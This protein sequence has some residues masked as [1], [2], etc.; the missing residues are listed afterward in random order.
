MNVL[1]MFV[2]KALNALAIS[3]PSIETHLAVVRGLPPR[4]FYP[5][6][7]TRRA[8]LSVAAKVVRPTDLLNM[9]RPESTLIRQH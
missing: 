7:S 3:T 6:A 9:A 2:K 4:S 5:N 1:P 8:R